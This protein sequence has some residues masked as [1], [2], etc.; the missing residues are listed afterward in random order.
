MLWISEL[1]LQRHDIDSF[2]MLKEV[3]EEH[4]HNGEIHFGMDVKPPFSDTPDDWEIILETAFSSA[5]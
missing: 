3:I 5:R 2:E 4:A 1:L